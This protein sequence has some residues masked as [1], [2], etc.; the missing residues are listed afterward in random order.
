MSY[1]A[2]AGVILL[3]VL[4]GL[5]GGLFLLRVLLQWA[6]TNFYNPICQF[7]YRATHPVLDPLRRVLRP[8]GRIDTAGLVVAWLLQTLKIWLILA[9]GSLMAGPLAALVLGVAELLGLLIALFFWL[10]IIRVILSFVGPSGHHPMV[11]L[12]AQLTEPLMRPWRRILP[13]PGGLD[14]SPMLVIL[15]LILARVLLVAPLHDLGLLL[16]RS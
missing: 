12:V 16:A 1:F 4:F 7:V 6:R 8:I 14:L 15:L 11:P 5:L 10:I 2:N 9:L 13:M 3:E